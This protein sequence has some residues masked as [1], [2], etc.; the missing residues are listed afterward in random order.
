MSGYPEMVKDLHSKL[1]TK[2]PEHLFDESE[3]QFRRRVRH[4]LTPK[5]WST[6]RDL[7]DILDELERK[8]FFGPGK[9]SELKKVLNDIDSRTVEEVVEPIEEEIQSIIS[10]LS[11][12]SSGASP[13]KRLRRD[14]KAGP[15][16]TRDITQELCMTFKSSHMIPSEKCVLAGIPKNHKKSDLD[17]K[18]AQRN[19]E[20]IVRLQILAFSDLSKFSQY[21]NDVK[22]SILISDGK[23]CLKGL[24]FGDAAHK[25][26]N[27]LKIGKEYNMSRFGVRSADKTFSKTKFEL[28]IYRTTILEELQE[29]PISPATIIELTVATLKE[30][31]VE[32]MYAITCPVIITAIGEIK[33]M[34]TK[35][36]REIY[37]KDSTGKIK[38]TFWYS[39]ENDFEHG[40]VGDVIE[41]KFVYVNVFNEEMFLQYTDLSSVEKVDSL[42]DQM[43]ELLEGE[44]SSELEYRPFS[45]SNIN[46]LTQSRCNILVKNAKLMKFAKV[47]SVVYMKCI[48]RGHGALLEKGGG[49]KYCDR[50]KQSYITGEKVVKLRARFDDGS[51]FLWASLY[52][53]SVRRV[54]LDKYRLFNHRSLSSEER[55]HILREIENEGRIYKLCLTV[56]P[57]Q[58]DDGELGH[59]IT[60]QNLRAV[61]NEDFNELSL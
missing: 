26:Q 43:E 23:I 9:Y 52:T 1:L 20:N 5:T 60:I 12:D 31:A 49:R 18:H 33:K 51:S 44:D 14:S 19:N 3:Q 22:L 59:N 11:E 4:H 58:L 13:N 28:R 34:N 8:G 35:F 24:A 32:K 2:L 53:T 45:I 30:S 25:V 29:T 56:K 10:N 47:E 16:Q 50:C 36:L 55:Y 27:T 17:F 7:P 57:F 21:D 46:Q 39:E 42:K 37:V 48:V 38:V 54:L 6:I 41:L 15:S 61:G 40:I